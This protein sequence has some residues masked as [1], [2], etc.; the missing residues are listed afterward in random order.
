MPPPHFSSSS[1]AAAGGSSGAGAIPPIPKQLNN[2]VKDASTKIRAALVTEK[3]IPLH[4][5]LEAIEALQGD[6][7]WKDVASA[8]YGSRGRAEN[9]KDKA[10]SAP[11]RKDD[12]KG[13]DSSK[14][15][16]LPAPP[17]P[18]QVAQNW[19][20]Q[21]AQRFASELTDVYAD[22]M[23]QGDLPRLSALIDILHHLEDFM[24]A[25]ALVT[26]WWDL[27][28]RPVLKNTSASALTALK[29]RNLVLRAMVSAPAS[30]YPDEPPPTAVWPA[31]NEPG[32]AVRKVGDAPYTL[33]AAAVTPLS[34]TRTRRSTSVSTSSSSAAG[35]AS[36]ANPRS[37]A[38]RQDMF[39][40]FAQRV[41]DL[42]TSEVVHIEASREEDDARKDAA[43][44]AEEGAAAS[45]D[46]QQTKPANDSQ[47]SSAVSWQSHIHTSTKE[48]RASD[49]DAHISAVWRSNLEAIVLAF[50]AAQSKRFFHHVAESFTD[51]SARVCLLVLLT[52]FLRMHSIHIY[53]VTSTPLPRRLLLSLQL[54][55][56]STV[57]ALGMTALVMLMP[58]IPD[59]IANGGAGGLPTC[60]SIMSRVIDWRKLGKGWEERVGEEHETERKE[61]DEEFAEVDRLARRLNI[62][63]ELEWQRVG[64]SL[65]PEIVQ[66]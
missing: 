9:D 50:G 1:A 33:A 55:T 62:R 66:L 27:L 22:E 24:P 37:G 38:A 54:D 25:A 35:P 59:W 44:E 10:G 61:L 26:D 28:L 65:L 58:H 2:L 42:Y 21:I 39:K 49:V 4:S 23:D 17:S 56:S 20:G 48:K 6:H 60:F 53:H 34:P 13:K 57:I 45:E 12:G 32:T 29:A 8:A 16:T 18:A 5:A 11:G 19:K 47:P 64:E 46:G 40:R 14:D 43:E 41:F 52:T 36:P 15:A 31:V 30:A 3:S 51:A 7:T 63:P